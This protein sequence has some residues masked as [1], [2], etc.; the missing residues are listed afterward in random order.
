MTTITFNIPD[1]VK[2]AFNETFGKNQ[3]VIITNLMTQAIKEEKRKREK[4]QA[5]K[6]LSAL[7]PTSFSITAQDIT[8]IH[9]EKK[10]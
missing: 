3:N 2:N 6:V 5:I 8:T 10:F 1:E 9:C 7:Q 4:I